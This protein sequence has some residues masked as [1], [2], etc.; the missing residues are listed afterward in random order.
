MAFKILILCTGNSAR[1]VMA[2]A[3]LG[4]RGTGRFE[5]YSAGSKP[6]GAVNPSGVK[7]LAAKG[8]DTDCYRSKSWDEFS[9]EEAPKM[10]AVITV[11]GNAADEVCP[12]WPGV[13]LT[14]HWGFPDPAA[15]VGT[16]EEKLAAFEEIYT[17]IDGYMEKLVELPVETMSVSKIKGAMQDIASNAQSEV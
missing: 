15:V 3:I 5:A 7:L 1:S 8:Y 11:C 17:A 12:V 13:P 9:G 4:R 2:E 6:A 14:V 16:E 10:D